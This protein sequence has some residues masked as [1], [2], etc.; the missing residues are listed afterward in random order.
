MLGGRL[1]RHRGVLSVLHALF[2]V[3]SLLFPPRLHISPKAIFTIQ[4]KR[5]LSA[6]ASEPWKLSGTTKACRGGLS[7]SGWPALKAV[8]VIQSKRP[9]HHKTPLSPSSPMHYSACSSSVCDPSSSPPFAGSY[10]SC[11]QGPSRIEA[12]IPSRNLI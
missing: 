10:Q 3:P 1:M 11:E 8:R 4:G 7:T 5:K 12:W 9:Q 6:P 2:F